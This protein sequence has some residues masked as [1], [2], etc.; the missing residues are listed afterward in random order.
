M[1][2]FT[3]PWVFYLLLGRT[4]TYVGER[5][6]ESLDSP[7]HELRKALALRPSCG[8]LEEDKGRDG[9]R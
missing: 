2:K 7:T 8:H 3:D 1:G 4:Y 9:L 5:G 6:V